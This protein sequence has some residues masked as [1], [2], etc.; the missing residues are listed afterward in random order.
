MK[1]SK[2]SI[3]RSVD[4]PDAKIRFYLFHGPDV[5]QSRAL[6]AR[7]L[8]ALGAAKT[9]LTSAMLKADPALLAAEAGTMSL[10]GEVRA[11]WIESAG[12][13]IAAAADALLEAPAVEALTIAIGGSLRKSSVLLKTAEASPLALAF[14]S[15][16]PEGQEAERMVIDLGRRYGLKIN[17]PLAARIA[18]QC[19]GDQAIAAQELQKLALY[20]DAS[21]HV[22]K[23]LDVEALDAVGAANNDG[24]FLRLA[25][26]ALHG[27]IAT[28]ADELARLPSAGSEAIPIIR[29]LQRRLLML[30]PARARIER[31]S[32]VEDAMASFGKTLFWK[33]KPLVER[34]L[35]NWT[36]EDLA[37]AAERAG[38]LERELMFT[39]A[40]E[41]EAVGEEL[42][43][44]ARKARRH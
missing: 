33:E 39:A 2:T 28:L 36:A 9:Q 41:R 1:A 42:L 32:S 30:A 18:G 15:Y 23:D 21:P 14:A 8:E 17:S 16:A 10:F 27:D 7:L 38:T 35:A 34:M 5:G 25:D 26:F 11:V 4:R 13:E 37:K 31:G 6:G 19:A 40:P 29:S 22:P 20:L 24:N 12:D 3:G 44:I 43:A